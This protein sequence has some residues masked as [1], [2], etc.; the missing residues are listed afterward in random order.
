MRRANP[1]RCRVCTTPLTAPPALSY[2]NMPGAA[3]N[4]PDADTLANDRGQDLDLH[5]CATCGLLQLA[6]PPVP[7]YREVIRAAAFSPEMRG[8]RLE[9]LAAWLD[10]HA[11]R[12]KRL[13]E[14]GCGRGEYLELLALAGAQ[15]SGLEYAPAAIAHCRRQGLDT[16]R[17]FLARPTQRLPVPAFDGFICLNFMEHWPRP[18]ASLRAIANNLVPGGIGLVEVPNFDMILKEGLYSEFIS[19]HLSYFTLDTL[20]FTLRQA[21]FEVLDARPVWHD[22][23]LSATVRKRQPADLAPLKTQQEKINRELRAFINR[24]PPRSV[25]VWGA[26]HQALAALALGDLGGAIRYVVDSAPFKQNRFTPATHLPIVPPA[27]L[28]DDPPAAIIVMAASYS[29]EVARL[30]REH[31]RLDLPVAVLRPHGLEIS[32]LRRNTKKT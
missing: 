27:R 31:H 16:L 13:L 29:D 5:E 24:F 11:L 25:A 12:G 15:A 22:Y 7:Y 19:D 18:V 1:P 32:P 14:I 8:F 30:I 10:R 20:N 9:Q 6:G 2:R 17:G 4:F 3:Q 28:A 23:I 21:G 26:G